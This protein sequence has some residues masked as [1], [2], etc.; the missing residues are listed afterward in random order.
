ML[1]KMTSTTIKETYL[2]REFVV[3]AFIF[4][5]GYIVMKQDQ[6]KRIAGTKPSARR[7]KNL[8]TYLFKDYD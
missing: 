3:L 5:A 4:I 2:M 7:S 1:H 8:F 6:A